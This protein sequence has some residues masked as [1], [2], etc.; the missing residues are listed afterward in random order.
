[1]II[2]FR[3]KETEKICNQQY[4][5]KLPEDI[6]R[7]GLR[8]LIIINRAK[9]LNDLNIPPGNKLEQLAGNR[10]GQYSIRINDQFRVCFYWEHGIASLVEITDY[11]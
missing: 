11:H 4:S 1:M 5:K 6:Q 2:S 8:K 10:Q 3:D 7:I 9:D